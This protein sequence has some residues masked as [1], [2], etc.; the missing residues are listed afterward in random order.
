LC[1]LIVGGLLIVS[2]FNMV[3]LSLLIDYGILK[4]I[5]PMSPM[6]V[7]ANWMTY[8]ILGY[9]LIILGIIIPKKIK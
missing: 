6:S 9:G 8:N 7:P 1:S 2:P 5:S 3:I 4:N